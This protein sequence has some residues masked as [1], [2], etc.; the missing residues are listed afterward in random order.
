M[1]RIELRL[2][3]AVFNRTAK[4]SQHSFLIFLEFLVLE[5]LDGNW[6]V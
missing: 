1:D 5:Q 2:V 4:I 6:E 3:S